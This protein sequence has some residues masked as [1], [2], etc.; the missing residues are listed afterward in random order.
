MANQNIARICALITELLTTFRDWNII[1]KRKNTDFKI[2]DITNCNTCKNW[3]LAT[4]YLI[5]LMYYHQSAK[6]RALNESCDGSA[7]QP[8]D[9]PTNAEGL[10]NYR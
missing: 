10:G 8:T 6:P 3:L 2:I 1:Y 5:L 9:N 4:E 7:G